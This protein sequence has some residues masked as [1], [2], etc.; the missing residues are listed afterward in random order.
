[1]KKIDSYEVKWEL[2]FK[3][4]DFGT[5]EELFVFKQ[6]TI[7]PWDEIITQGICEKEEIDSFSKNKCIKRIDKLILHKKAE[8]YYSSRTNVEENWDP[9][10]H[11]VNNPYDFIEE[12][13]TNDISLYTFDTFSDRLYDIN[14]DLLPRGILISYMS[15]YVN[16]VQDRYD[17]EKVLSKLKDSS[18]VRF[19]KKSDKEILEIPNSCMSDYGKYYLKFVFIPTKEEYLEFLNRKKDRLNAMSEFDYI[20]DDVLGLKEFKK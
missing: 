19:M 4:V 3:K 7:T 2:Y 14:G 8:Y 11:I 6:K 12:M 20:L 10:L 15:S 9:L 5:D 16:L 17:L 18:K 1:M 13:G